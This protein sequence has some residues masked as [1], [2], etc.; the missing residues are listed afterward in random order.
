MSHLFEDKSSLR[1]KQ[2]AML[3]LANLP[4]KALN[5]VKRKVET[6]AKDKG[7]KEI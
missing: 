1:W 3:V 4:A 7:E 2:E 6:Y 5:E